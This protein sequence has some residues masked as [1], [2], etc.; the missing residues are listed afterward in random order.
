MVITVAQGSGNHDG[1]CVPAAIGVSRAFLFRGP[2]NG[3]IGRQRLAEHRIYNKCAVAE[4][5]F[6]GLKLWRRPRGPWRVKASLGMLVGLAKA[7]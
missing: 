4:F 5:N 7:S 1:S 3:S 2:W 6:P